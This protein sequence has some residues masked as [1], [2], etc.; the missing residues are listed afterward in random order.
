[1]STYKEP[2][3][4]VQQSVHSILHQTY[5]NI[6]LII[7]VD[8]PLNSDVISYLKS[9]KQKDSRLSF[10]VNHHNIGLPACQTKLIVKAHGDYIAHMDADDIAMSVRLEQELKLLLQKNLDLVGTNVIDINANGK[11]LGTQT[12]YPSQDKNIKKYLYYGDCLPSSTWLFRKTIF[13]QLNG[14][15]NFP[16]CEDY[17]FLLRG[18]LLGFH[19][20]LIRKPL[21]YYRFNPQGASKRKE[22]LLNL[23]TYYIQQQYRKNNTFQL[24]E[25][26]DFIHSIDGNKINLDLI[27]YNRLLNNKRSVFSLFELFLKFIQSKVIRDQLLFK[28]QRKLIKK[29]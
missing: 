26:N 7:A 18:A 20:G 5:K 23:T 25:F 11:L 28:V 6:E 24:N 16:V 1:M 21:V 12:N 15:V 9:E 27:E 19:Y 22:Y 17:D 10:F 29:T 13:N 14:Y 3:E 4:Y 8:D 2:V